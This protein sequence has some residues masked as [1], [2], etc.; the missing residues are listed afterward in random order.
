MNNTL[1][2]HLTNTTAPY[3]P[4]HSPVQNVHHAFPPT[5]IVLA[6]ADTVI[7]PQSSRDLETRL[8][9][10]GVET[11][12]LVAEGMPHGALEPTP[13]GIPDISGKWW[14]AVAVPALEFCVEKCRA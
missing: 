10:L 1:N 9:A 14:E 6:E 13:P 8:K 5:A 11:R 3:P 4:E 7:D 12:L 2:A